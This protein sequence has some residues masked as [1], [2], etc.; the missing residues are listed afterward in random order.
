MQNYSVTLTAPAIA[1]QIRDYDKWNCFLDSQGFLLYQGEGAERQTDVIPL[2]VPQTDTRANEGEMP[3]ALGRR[4]SQTDWSH[5][6]QQLRFHNGDSAK[7]HHSEGID[8]SEIGLLRHLR[9]TAL[10]PMGA[11]TAGSSGRMAQTGNAT[12]VCDGTNLKRF[13]DATALPTTEDPHAGEGAVAVEDVAAEGA[14]LFVALGVNG[15]HLRDAAGVFTHYSAAAAIRVAFLKERLIAADARNLWE[16]TA[17]GAAPAAKLTLKEGWTFTSIAELDGFIYASAIH[18]AS[19]QTRIHRFGLDASLNVT[20]QGSTEFPENELIYTIKSNVGVLLLVGGRTNDATPTGKAAVVYKATADENGKLSYSLIAESKG[21]GTRDLA[22]RAIATFGRKF[23]FGWT[24]GSASPFGVREGIAVYDLASDS[25]THHL[26]SSLTTTTPDPVLGI[27]VFAGRIVFITIDGLYYEDTSKFVSQAYLI[28]STM[29]FGHAGLKNWDIS[30]ETHKELPSTCSVQLEYSMIEPEA[31][32]WNIAGTQAVPE[33]TEALYRHPG[34]DSAELS[35]KIVSN[36]STSQTSAPE[37]K[38]FSVRATPTLAQP[39][40]RVV[41]T[42]RIFDQDRGADRMSAILQNPVTIRD[43]LRSKI[44]KRVDY[45]ES[46]T[47]NGYAVRLV[48]MSEL[49]PV[50]PPSDFD[51]DP[52]GEGFICRLVL[53][54]TVN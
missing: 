8:V 43:W 39:E 22:S 17:S 18:E 6:A 37:I 38:S 14:R 11:L 44:N 26:F 3:S 41:R 25:F 53:E 12:F 15:I 27:S 50:P 51:G 20:W 31:G 33:S 1:S 2:Q 40:H 30:E 16:I 42:V 34:V 24:L 10:N 7:F 9:A 46:D 13:S 36:A 23:L 48:G 5:G 52:F 4:F 19:R 28:T 54:G 32:E 47:P 29:T 35:L 49:S 45:Y 21:A